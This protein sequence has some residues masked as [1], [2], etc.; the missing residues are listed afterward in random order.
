MDVI[1]FMLNE[2]FVIDSIC[3]IWA[4]LLEYPGV[5]QKGFSMFL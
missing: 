5:K 4:I 2:Y 3:S 1:K